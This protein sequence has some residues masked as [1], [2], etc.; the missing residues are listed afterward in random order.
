MGW[1]KFNSR[2]KVRKK[3]IFMRRWFLMLFGL[4]FVS[5]VVMG[6]VAWVWSEKYRERAKG[7]DLDLV[8]NLQIPDRIFDIDSH[9]LGR[10]FKENRDPIQ[11]DDVP[12]LF[13]DTLIAAEDAR[14]FS[15]NGYDI[16]GIT[17][18]AL[19]EL[20]GGSTSGGASTL[21]QQLARNAF[22]LKVW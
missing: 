6:V 17:R 4:C 16:K 21:T 13:I 7:Y 20:K 22:Y 12:Q 3:S 8:N 10:I 9:E 19:Q 15:H 18:V 14:F 11:V 1:K 5:V 2:R